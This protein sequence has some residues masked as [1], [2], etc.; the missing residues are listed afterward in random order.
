MEGGGA[1]LSCSGEFRL[2]QSESW[3]LDVVHGWPLDSLDCPHVVRE[4][5]GHKI[6]GLGTT[7]T[8]CV[9]AIHSAKLKPGLNKPGFTNEAYMAFFGFYLTG[10]SIIFAQS[11]TR[12][13]YAR[14]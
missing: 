5:K 11:Q 13:Y 4:P 3:R 8:W 7:P 2:D 6:G 9:G 1:W 14:V 12:V 10:K